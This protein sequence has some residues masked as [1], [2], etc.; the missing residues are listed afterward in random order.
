MLMTKKDRRG[1]WWKN[2]SPEERS[3]RGAYAVQKRWERQSPTQ[4][5]AYAMK[6]VRARNKKHGK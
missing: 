5:T 2:I 3:Y 1:Q 4:R 6:L